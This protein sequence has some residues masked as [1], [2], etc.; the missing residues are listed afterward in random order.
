M[1]TAFI[2]A[3]KA[4]KSV[5]IY[6]LCHSTYLFY[7]C[8][9]KKSTV[10]FTKFREKSYDFL[11]RTRMTDGADGKPSAS[12]RRGRSFTP[13]MGVKGLFTV[14]RYRRP[15]SQAVTSPRRITPAEP[16]R[17]SPHTFCTADRISA[18]I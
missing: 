9:R 12:G 4:R 18:Y 7:L 6:A 13:R 5:R 3:K 11:R 8:R 10:K 2:K 15:L 14:K 17:H 1:R 16:A